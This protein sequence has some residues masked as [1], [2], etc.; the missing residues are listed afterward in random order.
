MKLSHPIQLRLEQD[1]LLRYEVEAAARGMR[2]TDYLRDRLDRAELS[3]ELIALRSEVA[4]RAAAPT[5]SHDA[6][7]LLEML[8]LL[9]LGATPPRLREAHEFVRGFGL[10]PVKNRD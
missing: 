6:S 10:Q 8:F 7:A 5:P 2:L 9:R 4:S 3:D 1:K